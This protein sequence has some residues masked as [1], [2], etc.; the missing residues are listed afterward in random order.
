MDGIFKPLFHT[1]LIGYICINKTHLMRIEHTTFTAALSSL[2]LKK[3]GY[4]I[5]LFKA[6]AIAVIAYYLFMEYQAGTLLFDVDFGS[7]VVVLILV[8]R[9]AASRAT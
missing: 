9:R 5:V 6:L 1:Y 4:A 8:E 2:S 3:I 7:P